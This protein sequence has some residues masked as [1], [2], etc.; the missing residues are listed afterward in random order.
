MGGWSRRLAE[1][2]AEQARWSTKEEE[3]EGGLHRRSIQSLE[4]EHST[5]LV[6][7]AVAVVTKK[8]R[9]VTRDVRRYRRF[10]F[11]QRVH[12]HGPYRDSFANVV[13]LTKMR[14]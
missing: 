12:H 7:T 10:S 3:E 6:A 14:E 13:R 11:R 1:A 2:S 5:W 9:K 8:I 4:T